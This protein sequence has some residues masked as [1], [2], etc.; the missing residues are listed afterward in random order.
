MRAFLPPTE[1]FINQTVPG[2]PSYRI[3]ELKGSG[4]NGHVFRAHSEDNASDIACKIIPIQ[5]VSEGNWREELRRPNQLRS[6]GIV[7]CIEATV[8]DEF[9]C[10]LICS[11]YVPGRSL[12]QHL[13]D[14]R[15][16]LSLIFVE[17]FLRFILP[18]LKELRDKR[19]TH[20]DLHTGNILVEDRSDILGSDPYAFKLTDFSC[21]ATSGGTD[22]KDDYLQTALLIRELLQNVDYQLASARDR[23]VFD[24][25][26]DVF[27]GRYFL[28]SDLTRDPSVRNPAAIFDLVIAF[29]SNWNTA[30]AAKGSSL[31]SPFDYL[32]CEQIGGAHHL[33]KSLYS[34]HF[35]GL[36]SIEERNN[37]VLT[38]PRGCGKTTV[39]RNL[40]LRHRFLVEDDQPEEIRYI[41]IYYRCDDLYYAFPRY[42]LP[43][44]DAALNVP[45]HYITATLLCGLLETIEG[46]ARRYYADDFA[47]L[48]PT[49]SKA[50]WQILELPY[51]QIPGVLSFKALSD[52]LQRER[53][54]AVE[55]HKYHRTHV[56]IGNYFGPEMLGRACASLI[57][58][59][60]FAANLPIYFF[61]DDYSSPKV[62]ADLQRNLNRLLMQRS[63]ACFFKLS[64]ESPVSFERGDCDGKKLCRGQGV[65]SR[66][67]F[68]R[69]PACSS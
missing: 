45:L 58:T 3:V 27:L 33:L 9:A 37:I 36:P 8:W 6:V 35:L 11:D 66:K 64:T 43:G 38:G 40:S 15:H 57:E 67:C 20:G 16:K 53:S 13:L 49:V 62:T 52:R 30:E 68:F 17:R 10:V 7:H 5:N 39:Y 34:E 51:P 54:R 25:I 2:F 60:T 21:T 59:L 65:S 61:I 48:E 23:F 44:E 18:I 1:P 22:G 4:A 24:Q 46:W 42:R 32:S 63:A 69:I 55:K 47:R 29:D 19:L 50:L 31:S 26:N 28:E 12:K 56:N 41:G 14:H